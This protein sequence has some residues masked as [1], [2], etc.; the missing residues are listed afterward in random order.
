MAR[1]CSLCAKQQS[2]TRKKKIF[3]KYED[4]AFIFFT[5]LENFQK[6]DL[7]CTFLITFPLFTNCLYLTISFPVCISSCLM[8]TIATKA[9]R[10]QSRKRSIRKF[11]NKL[12]QM[13]WRNS[14][15]IGPKIMTIWSLHL[16]Y[17]FVFLCFC[18]NIRVWIYTMYT[19]IFFLFRIFDFF[20]LI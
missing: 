10:P 2:S 17:A 15:G 5:D 13:Y 1:N 19:K 20:N 4:G 18:T 6:F 11:T 16:V 14:R 9:P 8:A 3:E 12:K 7:L